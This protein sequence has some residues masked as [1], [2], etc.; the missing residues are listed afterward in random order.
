MLKSNDSCK[1]TMLFI[2]IQRNHISYHYNKDYNINK[3]KEEYVSLRNEINSLVT[4]TDNII[5]ILYTFLAA[6]DTFVFTKNDTVYLLFPYVVIIPV[7]FIVISKRAAMCKIS[8]HI[9]IFHEIDGNYWE[10]RMVLAFA[11]RSDLPSIA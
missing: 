11:F 9:S 3:E 2:I 6:Y 10:T 1:G 8:A 4:L 5:S 7:Y